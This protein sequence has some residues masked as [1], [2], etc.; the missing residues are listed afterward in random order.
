MI[1]SFKCED[2]AALFSGRR[3]PRF[4]NIRAAAE[5]KLEMLAV[6]A[7]LDFLRSPPGNRLE[8]LGGDRKGQHSIRIND[9]WRVCFVWTPDGPQ[10]V[11]IVDY[12]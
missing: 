6:A 4:A 11:E 7:S 1:Q 9:R 5:R 12:H 2:T 8:V 10:A 3:V